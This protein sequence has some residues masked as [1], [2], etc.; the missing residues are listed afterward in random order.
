MP[1]GFRI[2]F[3]EAPVRLNDSHNSNFY[4][5]SH[6]LSNCIKSWYRSHWNDWL[7]AGRQRFDSRLA[8]YFSLY[9]N[10]HTPAPA[11]HKMDSTE[12]F[13]WSYTVHSES[14]CALTKGAGSDVHERLYRSESVWFYSQTLSPDLRSEIR[15]AL[16]KDGS[17]VHERI[18]RPEPV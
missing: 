10:I 12:L 2:F 4:L 3:V 15:C 7:G 9:Q 6:R 1:L 5:I 8:R 18:H 16:I 13:F 14:R 17:D 11:S